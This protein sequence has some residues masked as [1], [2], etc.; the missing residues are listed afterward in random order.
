MRNHKEIW[1]QKSE[2]I[3]G[4]ITLS[5]SA[6]LIAA[7][8]FNHHI[9]AFEKSGRE[10]WRR[11][12]EDI[13]GSVAISKDGRFILAGS[14]DKNLYCY[15]SEGK[16][17]WQ[18]MT[19]GY[20]NCIDL[21]EN[22]DVILAGSYDTFIYCLDRQGALMWKYETKGIISCITINNDSKTILVGSHNRSVYC[23]DFN[24]NLLWKFA[25]KDRVLS[26]DNFTKDDKPCYLV[27]S[28]DW[29]IYMIDADGSEVWN[30]K[31]K[32]SVLSVFA[33]KKG[34]RIYAGSYDANI[35][36]FQSDGKVL[37]SYKTG[38]YVE[39]VKASQKGDLVVAT[40]KD[41]HLYLLNRSGSL[42][43]PGPIPLGI[44]DMTLSSDGKYIF[45]GSDKE[46]IHCIE[47]YQD[48]NGGVEEGIFTEEDL[49]YF[50]KSKLNHKE[51]DHVCPHCHKKMTQY[52][53]KQKSEERKFDEPV[54][55]E[56]QREGL[57]EGETLEKRD[58]DT[59]LEEEL[60]QI[61]VDSQ[62]LF[63]AASAL[64]MDTSAVQ[65]RM[66][67]GV[68]FLT[69]KDF[70]GASAILNGVI[71][72]LIIEAIVFTQNKM[73][74]ALESGEDEV[75]E[76]MFSFAGKSYKEGRYTE[77]LEFLT[78]VIERSKAIYKDVDSSMDEEFT[79]LNEKP[80]EKSTKKVTKKKKKSRHKSKKSK[81]KKR[82]S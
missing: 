61:I 26:C 11:E 7:G 52:Y 24:G 28:T 73:E 17:I 74:K 42:L 19:E 5:E 36:C 39:K 64:G 51:W 38:D 35:Y 18:Y 30:H 65:S 68:T 58:F 47:I 32:G 55:Q 44:F 59:K 66:K 77:S 67:E 15:D 1:H 80:K 8:S 62:P 76:E 45:M 10:L 6:E 37:W 31:T 75:L 20:I 79:N 12:C 69:Q 70:E 22:M 53:I 13:V 4:T 40:S 50:E 48:K 16:M 54:G 9:Y 21:S 60:T 25:T 82:G 23:F 34:N 3:I 33:E 63:D 81:K 72:M 56:L 14:F 57:V 2:G 78:K 46:M 41:K 27:G 49:Q 29:N 43:G 71:D